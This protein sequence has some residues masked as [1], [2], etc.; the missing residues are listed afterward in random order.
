MTKKILI[1]KAVVIP[2][3]DTVIV[4]SLL[5]S[6]L[7]S[8]SF[9]L[10]FLS[11]AFHNILPYSFTFFAD[12]DYETGSGKGCGYVGDDEDY[13]DEGSGK[14]FLSLFIYYTLLFYQ[15]GP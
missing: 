12:N 1:L 11:G 7:I 9:H 4:V 8:S 2:E 6:T 15:I 3:A 5:L 13:N 14:D 10:C